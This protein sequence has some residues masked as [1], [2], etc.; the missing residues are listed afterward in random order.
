M[1]KAR[2]QVS[3]VIMKLTA[4]G[5][6]QQDMKATLARGAADMQSLAQSNQSTLPAFGQSGGDLLQSTQA[7]AGLLPPANK[8]RETQRA[9]SGAGRSDPFAPLNVIPPTP[10]PITNLPPLP[11]GLPP[12]PG[13]APVPG[14]GPTPTPDPAQ[15]AKNVQVSGI[16]QIDRES[17]A[18][19]SANGTLPSVVQSG[20]KYESADVTSISSR[21]K[22]VVLREAGQT[23][24]HPIDASSVVQSAPVAKP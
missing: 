14:T 1:V 22:E 13:V 23:V 8:E 12:I 3:P 15:F 7:A 10:E 20:Q 4:S 9:L 19:V 16:I 11:T 18:L 6:W 2:D 21:K 5:Q 24:V 17:Y